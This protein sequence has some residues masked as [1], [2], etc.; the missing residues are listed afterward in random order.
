VE[1]ELLEMELA[2]GEKPRGFGGFGTLGP[3]T[4]GLV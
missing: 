2:A 1:E 3:F 4:C